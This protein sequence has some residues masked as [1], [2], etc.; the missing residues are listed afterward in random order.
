VGPAIAYELLIYPVTN[1]DFETGSYRELAE[2]YML[3]RDEMQLYWELYLA[4]RQTAP[5]ATPQVLRADLAGCRQR[6]SST[7]EYDPLR[8]EGDALAESCETL[9][10]RSSTLLLLRHDPT[11]SSTSADGET[12]RRRGRES[13]PLDGHRPRLSGCPSG[14]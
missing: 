8:D 2:G 9:A 10:C 14:P 4:Q 11:A 13:R 1:F 12:G 3:T 5:T 7:A 6:W